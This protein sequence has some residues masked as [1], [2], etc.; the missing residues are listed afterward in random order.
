MWLTEND[1]K[2]CA[3]RQCTQ[4]CPR[5]SLFPKC[6]S[7]VG[8]KPVNVLNQCMPTR[9]IGL[10]C[11]CTD[12]YETHPYSTALCADILRHISHK[13]WSVISQSVLRLATG[14]TVRG[15]NPGGDEIFRIRPDQPWGP[16]S[17]LYNGCQVF[18]WSKAA[19]AW[20]WPPTLV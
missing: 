2:Y 17:L 16:L 4:A 9:N 7:T 13:S 1:N 12:F 8:C 14:W 5:R 3:L 15:S 11:S 20:R 10:S 6:H 19:G 18:P